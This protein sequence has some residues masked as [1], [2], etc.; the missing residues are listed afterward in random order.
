MARGFHDF[1]SWPLVPLLLFYFG[2]VG[3]IDCVWDDSVVTVFLSHIKQVSPLLGKMQITF[4]PLK[5]YEFSYQLTVLVETV[6]CSY[7][8]DQML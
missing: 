6:H 3:T 7:I 5:E 8:L 2:G 1:L 4:F